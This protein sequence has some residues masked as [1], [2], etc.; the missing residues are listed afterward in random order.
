MVTRPFDSAFTVFD[1]D[2]CT[3]EDGL[4]KREYFAAM[5]LQGLLSG[6][7][8][9]TRTVAFQ[10]VKLADE[11]INELNVKN[12]KPNPEKQPQ[13]EKGIET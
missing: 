1:G 9:L 5:A 7:K 12:E 11:I 6:G 13:E 10:A 4:T 3:L 2:G 8:H